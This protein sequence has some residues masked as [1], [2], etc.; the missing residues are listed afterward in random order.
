MSADL[1]H[2]AGY[3]NTLTWPMSENPRPATEKVEIQFDLDAKKFYELFVR[4][5]T[6]ST[7]SH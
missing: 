5:M 4:L 2:G 6:A 7:P 3:G 1:D